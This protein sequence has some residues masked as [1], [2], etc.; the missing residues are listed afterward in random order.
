M[1]HALCPCHSGNL[2]NACCKPFHEGT[3]LP[4]NALQLMRSRYSAYACNL[5][6]YIVETTHPEHSDFNKD[7]NA[8]K[9]QIQ[10]FSNHTKFLNLIIVDFVEEG[11]IAY[12]TFTAQLNQNGHD[13]S[14]TEKSLFKKHNQ[15]WLYCKPVILNKKL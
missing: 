13:A 10:Q 5:P 8:W 4:K 2:Y 7:R 11:D 12:V 1:S 14:F 15:R 3:S 9:K 6:D